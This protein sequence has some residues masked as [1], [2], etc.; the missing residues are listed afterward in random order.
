[1][2]EPQ[3]IVRSKIV[4]FEQDGRT[5]K[6]YSNIGTAAQCQNII[7]NF[8]RHRQTFGKGDLELYL[9]EIKNEKVADNKPIKNKMAKKTKETAMPEKVDEAVKPDAGKY[10]IVCKDDGKSY[11]APVSQ[12]EA[13]KQLK[14]VEEVHKGQEFEIKEI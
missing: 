9:E 6:W 7:N 8:N 12:K 11:S 14:R 5:P 3:Y 2:T 1:M 13:E 4:P 10:I